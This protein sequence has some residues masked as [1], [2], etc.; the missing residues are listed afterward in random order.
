MWG[1]VLRDLHTSRVPSRREEMA[2][3]LLQLSSNR[4][5]R[6]VVSTLGLPVPLPEQ[7]E[8]ATGPWL[9]RPLHDRTVVVGLGHNAQ[10]SSV[11]A[12]VLGAAG[13]DPWV[14]GDEALLSPW[15][16]AGE[17]WGRPPHKEG[18]EEGPLRPWALLFDATGLK[19]PE[20]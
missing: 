13:A 7:L 12:R 3:L 4:R 18:G 19:A 14:V 17:A 5:A 20:E 10:L 11:L 9:E 8:R 2:D 6:Q 16:E 1:R 15:K